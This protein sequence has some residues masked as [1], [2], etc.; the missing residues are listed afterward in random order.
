MAR[1][2]IT[3]ALERDGPRHFPLFSF[4]LDG[5]ALVVL[6]LSLAQRQGDLRPTILEVE[7]QRNQGQAALLDRTDHLLDFSAVQQELPATDRI[8]VV[9][10]ALF[11]W[12]DVHSFEKDFPVLRT[13]A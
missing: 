3:A 12:R 8:V 2:R 1:A 9:A 6:L 4:A 5:F 7:L 13:L 11:V 10:I